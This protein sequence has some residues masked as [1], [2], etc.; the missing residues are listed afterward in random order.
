MP[1]ITETMTL[2]EIAALPGYEQV[3]DYLH[4]CDPLQ[5]SE[6]Y[7]NS[8]ARVR[9]L[10]NDGTADAMLVGLQRLNEVVE[11][12]A[13]VVYDIWSAAEKAEVPARDLTRLLHFPG[14]EGAPFVVVCPGGSY[15]AICADTDSFPAA[16]A[17]NEAGYHAF[18]LSYRYLEAARLPAPV[19]DLAQAVRYVLAHAEELGVSSEYAA[20]GSSAAGHMVGLFGSVERGWAHYGVPEPQALVFNFPVI[21]LR[22]LAREDAHR[23][24]G[25]MLDAAFG[26]RSWRHDERKLAEW[27][28]NEYVDAAYPPSYLW[29]CEDDNIVPIDNLR[30][31]DEALTR[32]GVEH[33][34]KTYPFGGHGLMQ[35]HDAEADAWLDGVLSFL[36]GWL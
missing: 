17:L 32:A 16:A 18:V 29:Q 35:P 2:A 23:Y 5:R 14:D 27:S 7:Q 33:A 9:S 10:Q 24:A 31:M 4:A 13:Q 15:S 3:G 12:G 34:T 22:T 36:A 8:V 1:R 30:L 20:M 19:E 25:N 26:G 6:A 28:V 21:D 11:S